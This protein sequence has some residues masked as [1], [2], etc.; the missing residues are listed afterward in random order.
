MLIAFWKNSSAG[1]LKV[2]FITLTCLV[3]SLEVPIHAQTHHPSAREDAAIERGKIL[4]TADQIDILWNKIENL[5]KEASFF[6]KRIQSLEEQNR[7]LE[8]QLAIQQKDA[9]QNRKALLKEVAS[10]I[11]DSQ[12]N[13][14][15]S[16]MASRSTTENTSAIPE[17]G[18]EH[19]VA[20]GESLWGI[21]RNYT[22]QGIK[23][24]VEDIRLANQL[25]K[26]QI[27]REGQ[28]LFIPIK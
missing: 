22:N 28:K 2:F 13:G 19:V 21:S 20:K 7:L 23:V 16:S 4:R 12:K 6:K 27:I 9:Q 17:K 24:T 5:E 8:K 25:A 18:Y 10:I 14:V 11:E 3:L 1:Y 15:G 26:G